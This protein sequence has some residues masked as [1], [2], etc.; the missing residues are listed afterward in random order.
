MS[1]S[2]QVFTTCPP[3]VAAGASMAV[4]SGAS[5]RDRVTEV[6]RWSE[7]AGCEGILVYTDNRL[8]D[9]WLTAQLIIEATERL[10]P[11]V[12]VQPVYMHP[13]TVAKMV[14]TFG[15]FYNRKVYF[16]PKVDVCGWNGLATVAGSNTST[17]VNGAAAATLAVVRNRP[18]SR[19]RAHARRG[20]G[21]VS[22]A[23]RHALQELALRSDPL[24]AL[25]AELRSCCN[26]GA[27]F[28]TR[29]RKR[30]ATVAAKL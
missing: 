4:A 29:N 21:D 15:Y 19:G 24:P 23:R 1:L 26:A 16:F 12:A 20:R 8:V 30:C 28:R 18:A 22:R 27:A 14:G 17:F 9:P 11:L 7:A 13:Y 6:A 25:R 5:Y 2:V 10:C 3:S